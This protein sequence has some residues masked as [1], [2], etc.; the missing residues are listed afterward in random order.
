[1]NFSGGPRLKA[2][3]VV[4]H[5]MKIFKEP[6]YASQMGLEY[7]KQLKNILTVP[8]YQRDIT[9]K[10]WKGMRIL[11]TVFLDKSVILILSLKYQLIKHWLGTM[12]LQ[13]SLGRSTAFLTGLITIISGKK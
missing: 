4:C 10:T 11:G 1:M 8:L 3:D 7:C 2:E 13:W 9:K 12:G 5:F 6:R